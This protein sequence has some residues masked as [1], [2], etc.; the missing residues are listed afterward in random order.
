MRWRE[1]QSV[2]WRRSGPHTAGHEGHLLSC[3]AGLLLRTHASWAGF[4]FSF[5]LEPCG[6]TRHATPS[7]P[8]IHLTLLQLLLSTVL[9]K[10]IVVFKNFQSCRTLKAGLC[11]RFGSPGCQRTSLQT[12]SLPEVSHHAV[13]DPAVDRE[14]KGLSFRGLDLH[15]G[16]KPRVFW[17]EKERL[18]VDLNQQQFSNW[19]G[20]GHSKTCH[21]RE[22]EQ[23][24]KRKI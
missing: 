19:G 1:T 8:I 9:A 14:G 22:I 17:E 23:R 3:S 2:W 24:G 13:S 18:F 20:T 10:R 21:L 6:K 5:S 11:D 15:L 4:M 7:L 12:F 16:G